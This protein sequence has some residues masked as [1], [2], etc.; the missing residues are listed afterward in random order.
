MKFEHIVARHENQT[1]IEIE[2]L[3]CPSTILHL[4]DSHMNETD[5]R[6]GLDILAESIRDYGFDA[7]ETRRFFTEALAYANERRCDGVVL[8]G[9]IVN[10]ATIN[11]LDYLDR[12]LRLLTSPYLYT[13]GNHDWEYPFQAWSDETRRSQYPKFNRFVDGNPACQSKVVNGVNLMALDN[14]TYQI[15]EKQLA[16][17]EKQL[18]RGLPTLLFMHIPIYIPSLLEDVMKNWRA[19]I[20]MAAEGWDKRLQKTWLVEDPTAETRRFYRLLMEN[21]YRNLIA[22]FCG[23]VHFAHV[24]AF[25]Q[26]S[27]QYVTKAGFLGG[28]RMIRLLPYGLRMHQG[29]SPKT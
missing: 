4:T 27:Y 21:P 19:P 6:E 28:Y 14:S 5:G 20:M 22:V 15:T 13:L 11:N 16:F 25:G 2:G 12:Q 26:G 23:H 3:T 29:I 17:A 24:D 18:A 10:G 8:T 9:D 7:L 1:I